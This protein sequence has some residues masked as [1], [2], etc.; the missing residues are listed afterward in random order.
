MSLIDAIDPRFVDL[1]LGLIALEALGLIAY[2]VATGRGPAPIGTLANLLSGGFLILVLRETLAGASAFWVVASLTAALIAH[3]VDLA[4]RWRR[5]DASPFGPRIT[6]GA[7]SLTATRKQ[8]NPTQQA[9][10]IK[11]EELERPHV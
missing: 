6:R 7:I 5:G 4:V 9:S 8:T 10:E 3:G 11:T 2:F 1:A